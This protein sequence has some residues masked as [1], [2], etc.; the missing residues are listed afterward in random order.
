MSKFLIL[1]FA[2]ASMSLSTI[3]YAGG[4]IVEENPD[5]TFRTTKDGYVTS[6]GHTSR[7]DADKEAKKQNKVLKKIEKDKG[8]KVKKAKK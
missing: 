4:V 3:L 6:G 1:A 5:G 8:K 2:L 7:K